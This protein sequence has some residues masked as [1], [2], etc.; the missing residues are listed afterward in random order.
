M[1]K[2]CS[3]VL[4]VARTTCTHMLPQAEVV[5]HKF[6]KVITLFGKCHNIYNSGVVSDDEISQLG[7]L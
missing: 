1:L 5:Y 7:M 6:V 3:S 4:L 2:H